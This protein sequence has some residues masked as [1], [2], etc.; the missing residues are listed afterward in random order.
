MTEQLLDEK[1]ALAN[2]VSKGVRGLS[3]SP[4][5]PGSRPVVLGVDAS[6]PTAAVLVLGSAVK[7]SPWVDAFKAASGLFFKLKRSIKF[8]PTSRREEKVT[9]DIARLPWEV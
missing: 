7:A 2:S 8:D 4:G 3:E 9:H 5:V 1:A 6:S